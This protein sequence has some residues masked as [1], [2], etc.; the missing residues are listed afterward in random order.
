MVLSLSTQ[1]AINLAA[2]AGPGANN[3]NYLA[4]YTAISNDINMRQNKRRNYRVVTCL[5]ISLFFCTLGWFGGGMTSMAE[6]SQAARLI[7]N[8]CP[9]CQELLDKLGSY[10]LDIE[11]RKRRDDSIAP[12]ILDQISANE[13]A[14]A[15]V[16][17]KRFGQREIVELSE[18]TR[19][20]N[21]PV[22]NLKVPLSPGS[23]ASVDVLVNAKFIIKEK[24]N[25]R[26][27]EGSFVAKY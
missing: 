6:E 11:R 20:I 21:I 16:L 18:K 23:T 26:T 4:A 1:T 24:A 7:H 12:F 25:K 19:I 2:T 15:E 13:F 17:A 22:A 10:Y 27:I 14:L 5:T 8:E 3:Q 9:D